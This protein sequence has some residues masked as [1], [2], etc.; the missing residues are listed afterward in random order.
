LKGRREP[1]F[2]FTDLVAFPKCR[3]SIGARTGRSIRRARCAET[4]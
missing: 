1:P 2:F 4:C 3:R